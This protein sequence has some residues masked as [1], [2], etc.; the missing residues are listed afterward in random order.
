M[1][2]EHDEADDGT[3][4]ET[5]HV[6]LIFRLERASDPAIFAELVARA[7]CAYYAMREG[8]AVMLPDGSG[9]EWEIGPMQEFGAAPEHEAPGEGCLIALILRMEEPADPV[10]VAMR[11]AQATSKHGV[12]H[13]G[14]AVVLPDGSGREWRISPE[15]VELPD[16]LKPADERA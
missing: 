13:P 16:F 4:D 9:R 2:G 3:E 1:T 14:E 15:R 11:L 12:L 7:A 6:A 5:T 10:F 8:E